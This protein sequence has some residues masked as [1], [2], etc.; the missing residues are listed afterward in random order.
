MP[1]TATTASTGP[2]TAPSALPSP[3]M[4]PL[5]PAIF[6]P[7]LAMPFVSPEKPFMAV[8]TVE[9]TLP[10]RMSMGPM[11]ATTAAIFNTVSFCSSFMPF[12]LSTNSWTFFAAARIF[13]MRIS[14]KE[15]ASPSSADFRMVI[16]PD[17]LSSWVS[18]ICWAAPP[19]SAMDCWRLSQLSPVLESS[20]LTAA[21]SVLLKMDEMMFC[22][23][24]EVIPS[25]LVF[26]SPRI[27]LR[28]RILPS[29]S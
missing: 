10:K 14:P 5:L 4:E 22:F 13:G 2:A 20:E 23:S 9:V 15:M 18:A 6:T 3:V 8:P 1:I 16:W 12:S 25:I 17:R 19:L 7:S 11:A 26:K 24:A 28:E 21:R 29:E 27:S